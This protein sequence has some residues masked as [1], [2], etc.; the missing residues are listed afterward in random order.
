MRRRLTSL[1]TAIAASALLL[2]A[3]GNA[4]GRS[5]NHTSGSHSTG[6]YYGGGHH[7]ESH[8]AH[9]VGG[10]GS[11]HKGGHYV[12]LGPGITTAIT[13]PHPDR[14]GNT[15]RGRLSDSGSTN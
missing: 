4:R 6:P 10:R 15:H 2:P 14:R 3:I 11:S 1:L 13:S 7:T 8:G 12:N 9:Y 5:G